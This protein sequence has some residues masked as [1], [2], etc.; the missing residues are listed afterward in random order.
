[1]FFTDLQ[2]QYS[3]TLLNPHPSPHPLRFFIRP[4]VPRSLTSW[5]TEALPGH[6]KTQRQIL[7]WRV[8]SH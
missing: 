6:Q 5:L 3:L 7:T 4:A 2:Q 1:M 8:G